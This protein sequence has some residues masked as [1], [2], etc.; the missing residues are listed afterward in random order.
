[1]RAWILRPTRNEAACRVLCRA[2]WPIQG[3]TGLTSRDRIGEFGCVLAM[4]LLHAGPDRQRGVRAPATRNRA[5]CVSPEPQDTVG[6]HPSHTKRN[7]KAASI[8][9]RCPGWP[10]PTPQ[11][12]SRNGGRP[13]AWT[14]AAGRPK[15]RAYRKYAAGRGLIAARAHLLSGQRRGRDDAQQPAPSRGQPGLGT[16]PR[17]LESETRKTHGPAAHAREL[18]A[19]GSRD[20]DDV[21][22]P[23]WRR[24][25]RPPEEGRAWASRDVGATGG[26]VDAVATRGRRRPRGQ[27]GWDVKPPRIDLAAL[28]TP[29]SGCTPG[30]ALQDRPLTSS[31]TITGF[32]WPVTRRVPRVPD[33]RSGRGR[34]AATCRGWQA[35]RPTSVRRPL[36]LPQQGLDCDLMFPGTPPATAI[37]ER[38]AGEG[39]RVRV[40]CSAPWEPARSSTTPLDHANACG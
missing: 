22:A 7:Q 35:H 21:S 9:T 2:G 31:E 40:C 29:L 24:V 6:K 1:M 38:R 32:E 19:P 18:L 23:W 14:V 10:G 16:D 33:G 11:C 26:M 28:P 3:A 5:S 20:L 25:L 39:Y 4:G 37:G 13:R 12:S 8:S 15:G 34:R 30:G 27:P 36:S 17:R